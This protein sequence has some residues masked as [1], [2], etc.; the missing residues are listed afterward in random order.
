MAAGKDLYG[1]LARIEARTKRKR[2]SGI[3][4][5]FASIFG[6]KQV[7]EEGAEEDDEAKE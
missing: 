4:S 6:R 5:R 7:D 1:D 2:Q 3:S